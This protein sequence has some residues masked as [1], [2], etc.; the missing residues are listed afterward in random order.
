MEIIRRDDSK[1]EELRTTVQHAPTLALMILAALRLAMTIAVKIVEAELNERANQPCSWPRCPQ[2]NARIENRGHK[3]RQMLT[4][5]GIV[6]WWRKA[7]RCPNGCHIGLIAPLD[8]Q[9]GLKP[10]QRVSL[11]LQRV[12]CALAIFVPYHLASVLLMMLTGI[13]IC[14]QT[15]WNWVQEVGKNTMRQLEAQLQALAAGIEPARE[16]LPW[17][18]AQLTLIIGA[19]GVNV[20]FRPHAGTP[21]G[22]TV[23][24]EVKVGIFAR[25]RER[26]TRYGKVW[27]QV[28]HRRLVAFL[29][30]KEEFKKRMKLEAIKQGIAHVYPVIWVSDGGPAFWGVFHTLRQL[31]NWVCGILDFYHA[32]Q[33]LWK[34][35]SAFLDGR[36]QRARQWF[37]YLRHLLR[38][39][40]P[41]EV[42]REISKPLLEEKCLSESAQKA[43]ENLQAYL[44]RHYQHISYASY[45][46]SGYPLGSGIVESACKW[47][48]Q[49]RFKGVGMRWSKDGFNHLLHLRLAWV[50]S[51]FDELFDLSLPPTH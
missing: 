14:P 39:R 11:E 3:H 28:V 24:Y 21:S 51:R 33:N 5:I 46:E 42:L 48:I 30:D 44:V 16:A 19:D 47:L 38:H 6:H 23:Y 49:Q 36:T 22:K 7:G 4:L 50:N 10:N 31:A 15:L 43:L 45:K 34:A 35:A 25:L 29:G 18:I 17:I 20:P 9:L 40:E 27:S 1:I 12:A 41:C 37:G 8:V 32:A 26:I 13:Q 2:C